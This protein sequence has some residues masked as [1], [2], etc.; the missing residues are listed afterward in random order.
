[1]TI[2][3]NPQ[4]PTPDA[5]RPAP[6][7]PAAGLFDGPAEAPKRVVVTGV[8]AEAAAL[9][10]VLDDAAA[11]PSAGVA[12]RDRLLR[13][14]VKAF[15]KE[16]YKA[17]ALQALDAAEQDPAAAAP[18]HIVALALEKLGQLS[19]ALHWYE[20][21][22]ERDPGDAEIYINLG[23]LAWRMDMI[24]VS[25]KLFRIHLS[26]KP[27]S[28]EGVNN[29]AG[30]LRDHA[31]LGDATE[32]LRTAIY[33]HP[34]NAMLWNSLGTVMNEQSD[35]ENAL[36]FFR[37]AV[38]LAPDFGRAHHNIGHLLSAV[39]PLDEAL[40][41]FKKALKHSVNRFDWIEGEHGRALSLIGLGRLE[42]GWP[43]YE[44]R[45]DPMYHGVTFFHAPGARW[46][47][48]DLAGKRLLV[49]AEQGLGD[50]ILFMNVLDDLQARLGPD[51]RLAL[52][53]DRRLVSLVQRSFPSVKVVRHATGR[54]DNKAVRIVPW[55][56]E[57]E[58]KEFGEIDF[59]VPLGSTLQYFRPNVESFP[60]EP[61]RFQ[62][63]P[64]RVA[65]WRARLQEIGP[66]PFVGVSWRS[67]I[68]NVARSKYFSPFEHWRHIF[69]RDDVT[70]VNLQYGDVAAELDEAAQKFGAEVWTPDDLDLM[71]DLDDNAALCS[72]LDLVIS[73]PNA[74]MNIAAACGVPTWTFHT[75]G[76]W[77]RLGTDRLPWYPNARVF[78]TTV[79]GEWDP[80]MQEMGES[81][82]A[83]AAERAAKA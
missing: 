42:E 32:L 36:T 37:E 39:G 63:D 43:A 6:S 70:F 26:L 18:R 3:A 8:G 19:H 34:E 30:V 81:L 14:A 54:R 17:A 55:L 77:P 23:L 46:E 1:M 24:D 16:D 11:A 10:R 31:K 62:A 44:V 53:V 74:A 2:V 12:K 38:R 56:Q 25:E 22:V 40:A 71:N 41:N 73:A 79:H 69:G 47:G 72:A 27:D 9:N 48:E 58:A 66:G 57:E 65:H 33:N 13:R 80:L 76:S 29:L 67:K 45:N 4:T 5:G 21:A 50:E 52:A 83:F 49:I 64:E 82:G 35:I 59:S 20:M 51:G 15:R 68:M 78:I 61:P 75:P 60:A 7:S 28:I